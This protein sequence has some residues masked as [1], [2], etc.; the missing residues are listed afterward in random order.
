MPKTRRDVTT[1]VV[2]L[3]LYHIASVSLGMQAIFS[4]P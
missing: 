1:A 2:C 4:I 3:M